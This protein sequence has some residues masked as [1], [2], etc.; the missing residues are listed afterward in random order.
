MANPER[1]LSPHLQVYRWQ[2]QMVTS[3]LHRATGVIL[4]VGSLL[5]AW[6]LVALAGGPD[7]WST[8]SGFARSWFG[9]LVMFGWTWALAFHLINGVRHLAQDA[10]YAFDIKGT[11]RNS[12]ISV[13]GSLL[14]TA[15]IWVVAMMQWGNA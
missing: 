10:G 1:P 3:I 11:I 2:V 13:F 4:V 9:F 12:W 8:F 7:S 15:V 5:V 6:A 14:L